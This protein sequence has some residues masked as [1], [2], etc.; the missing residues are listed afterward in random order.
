ME[1]PKYF[2][3]RCN[4]SKCQIR[5][6]GFSGIQHLIQK[7]SRNLISFNFLFSVHVILDRK[8]DKDTWLKIFF[9]IVMFIFIEISSCFLLLSEAF[10]NYS[11]L[12]LNIDKISLKLTWIITRLIVIGNAPLTVSFFCYFCLLFCNCPLADL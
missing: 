7:V 6:Y 4:L 5:V 11:K 3:Q 12:L 2:G 8:K 1:S 10:S 9:G